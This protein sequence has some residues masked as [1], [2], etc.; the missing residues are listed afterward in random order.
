MLWQIKNVDAFGISARHLSLDFAAVCRRKQKVVEQL[1]DGVESL[2]R[3]NNITVINGIGTIAGPGKVRVVGEEEKM[4]EADKIIIATGSESASVPIE[5]I[6]EEGVINSDEA[7]TMEYLPKSMIIIGGGIIGLEFAQIFHRMNVKVAIIEMMP[8]ILPTED[9]DIAQMLQEILEEEG[10]D[11]YTDAKVMSI[12]T[13]EQGN[14]IVSFSAKDGGEKLVVNKVLIAV[15]RIP[16]TKAL[17]LEKLGVALDRGR[18]VVNSRMETNIKD[19]Y[20]IGDVV[21]GSMLAHMAMAEGICAAQNAVGMGEEMDYRAVPRCV[22]TSPEIAAVGLTEK[23]AE[24]KYDNVRVGKFPFRAN[25]KA[26]VLDEMDGMV[27]F[28]TD[29]Q[30]GQVLG[31]GIIGSHATEMIAETVLGIQLE[32]TINDFASAIHA[33]PTLSEAVMEAA[34]GIE[35]RSIHL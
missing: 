9:A 16:Y 11:I 26:L 17:G 5:G 28:I 8:Q 12:G 22:Y 3:N 6:D 32:A 27:K 30:Y 1:V 15:G 29:A 24:E 20:A 19:I 34:L 18:I 33:H 31:V 10:I 13:N 4:I 2:M 21:G 7:L 25:A 35:G 14:K 23:E